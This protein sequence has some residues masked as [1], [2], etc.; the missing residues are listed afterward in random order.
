MQNIDGHLRPGMFLTV[1]LLNDSIEALV[2]PE[3]ALIPERSVQYVFVVGDNELVEKRAVQIG[4]RRPGEVEILE[5]LSAGESVI[6]DGTQ[7]ARDGQ[8]VGILV[9]EAGQP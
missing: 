5:G 6:V 1:N 9:R 3:R 7:K 8:P 4:R 2:V